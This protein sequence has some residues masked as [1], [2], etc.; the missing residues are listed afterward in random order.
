MDLTP[1]RPAGR[2]PR[3][4]GTCLWNFAPS[5]ESRG[6]SAWWLQDASGGV[7]V[8]VPAWTE[9][10]LAFLRQQPDGLILLTHRG[11]HGRC[12]HFQEALGWAVW[13]QEQEAYLLPGVRRLHTFGEAAALSS[14]LKLLWTP[15]HSPG[16]AVLHWSGARN[17]LFCGRTLLP[18]SDGSAAPLRSVLTFHWGRQLASIA[19]LRHWPAAGEPDNIACG[20]G[21]GALRGAHL[22]SNG[23][24]VLQALDLQMLASVASGPAFASV[25]S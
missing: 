19:A 13:V 24:A 12:R 14:T 2:P 18:R 7:L 6:G 3:P 10:N 15:G 8:D 9:A 11:N 21:L 1:P 23:A 20:A 4:L 22:V 16:S 25:S 5:R 17:L